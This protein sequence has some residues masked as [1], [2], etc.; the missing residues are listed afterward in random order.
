MSNTEQSITMT[1]DKKILILGASSFVGQHLAAALPDGQAIGTYNRMHIKGARHF[2]SLTMRIRDIID[3]SDCPSHA[4]ILMGDTDPDSCI[5]DPALS[6]A[7]NVESTRI[8]IDDLLALGVKIIF[9][10]TEFVFDGAR[11]MYVESDPVSP[12]LLYGEQKVEIER[13]LDAA[14]PDAC[15]LRL[16]KVYGI[17]PGDG[18]LFTGMHETIRTVAETR[19][20]SDQVFSPVYVGTVVDAIIAAI[21]T[22]IHGIYHVAGP[23]AYSRMECLELMLAEVRRGGAVNFQAEPCSILGFDL[24]EARPLNVSMC[25]D[26]LISDTQIQP[27]SAQEACRRICRF[28]RDAA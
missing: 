15:I 6:R 21:E 10:S 18:T 9:T 2:D 13:Y 28:G 23:T 20:A 26:K 5:A 17:T 16:A 1:T 7:V 19:C 25:P 22:S 8:V 4:I 11:G 27:L 12:I 14:A 24:P 3:P